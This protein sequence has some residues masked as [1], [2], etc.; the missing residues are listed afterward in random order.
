MIGTVCRAMFTLCLTVAGATRAD[1]GQQ[2][3]LATESVAKEPDCRE[4]MADFEK[5]I[6]GKSRHDEGCDSLD[7]Y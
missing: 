3:R 5:T 6:K 1:C 4:I 7:E 2:R